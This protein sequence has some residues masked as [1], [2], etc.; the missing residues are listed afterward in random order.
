MKLPLSLLKS[1]IHT[2]L[3]LAQIA[4]SLTLLGIEVDAIE[5]EHPPF[6]GVVVAE[7]LSTERHPNAE[8]LQVAQVHDGEKIHQVVCGAPNCRAG[9]KTAFARVG[10][11]LTDSKGG[12]FTIKTAKLRGV[13]SF[14]MLCSAEELLIPT[15]EKDGIL[16]LDAALRTGEELL[17]LVWDPVFELSLTP[18]LGYCLSAKGVAKELAAFLNISVQPLQKGSSIPSEKAQNITVSIEESSLCPRYMGKT[19]EEVQ[20]G[21]SPFW[22]QQVLRSAGMRP[23]NNAV[24]ITNYLLLKWGQPMHAFDADLL[25]KGHLSVRSAKQEGPFSCLDGIERQVPKGTLLI[26]DDKEP[27]ALAG[28]MGGSSSAVSEKT[29]TIF[30]EVAYFDPTT[31]RKASKALNLRSESSLRFEK[32]IDP[33]TMQQA[34]DEA[35]ELFVSLCKGRLCNG[36]IDTH[37]A[38]FPSRTIQCRASR[39]NK[40]LGTTIALHEIEE[41][42]HRLQFSTKLIEEDTL[43]VSIPSHRS[44]LAEEIDLIEEVARIYGYNAIEKKPPLYATTSLPHDSLFLFEKKLRGSLTALGLQEMLTCDLISPKLA[45]LSL[46][47][48]LPHIQCLQVLHAKSEEYSILRPSLLPGFLQTVQYNLDQKNPNVAGFEIGH[49]YFK[50][51][52]QNIELPMAGLFLTGKSSPHHWDRKPSDVDFY[53]LKGILENLFE[54][55][56]LPQIVYKQSNHPSFHPKRQASF[57]L[58]DQAIGSLGEIHPCLLEPLDIKQR[59]LYAE[60]HLTPLLAGISGQHLMRALPL[61]PSSERDWTIPLPKTAPIQPILD[62]M[63]AFQSPLL[64]KW[65]LIDLFVSDNMQ[66]ITFRFTYRDPLKTISFEQVEEEHAKV[67]QIVLASLQ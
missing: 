59:V 21:P 60:M 33:E 50:E 28:I 2:D 11:R 65:E 52:D 51:N 8:K 1:F 45:N 27:V 6:I 4:E 53:D 19:I 47:T 18:N 26:C 14:G 58:N 55:L 16:E 9:L 25:K 15:D 35:C 57:Y 56:H 64:E 29:R 10:A 24:D 31:I 39:V 62:T 63:T 17:P 48:K 38:P 34:L 13:D 44:D 20:I 67:M 37:P 3:P 30:L 46:E 7:V 5:N 42:F 40:I 22:L 41:I 49:I 54:S 32:G 23:I 66:H 12:S 36:T 61:F 43:I